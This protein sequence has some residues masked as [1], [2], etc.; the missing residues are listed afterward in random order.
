MKSGR[1]KNGVRYRA[2]YEH[3]M[4]YYVAKQ[5][6]PAAEVAFPRDLENACLSSSFV[7]A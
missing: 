5:A 7:A 3:V 1:S 4:R 6:D 2:F